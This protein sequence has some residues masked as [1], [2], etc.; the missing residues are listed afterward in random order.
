[1]NTFELY[2]QSHVVEDKYHAK[3]IVLYL[4]KKRQNKATN[5]QTVASQEKLLKAFDRKKE[6]KEREQD[7]SLA[8]E[9]LLMV[10]HFLEESTNV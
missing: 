7:D 9:C 8:F 10:F 6:E 3:Q 2:S 5:M 4:E 1:M